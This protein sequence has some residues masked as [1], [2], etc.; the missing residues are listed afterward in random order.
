MPKICAIL[1]IFINGVPLG[2]MDI[3]WLRENIGFVEQVRLEE[4]PFW[5]TLFSIK[6]LITESCM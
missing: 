6:K 3:S 5:L 4:T 1:Q 2:E